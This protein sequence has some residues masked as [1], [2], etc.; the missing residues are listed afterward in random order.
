MFKINLLLENSSGFLMTEALS[1]TRDK[2]IIV[3]ENSYVGF[4]IDSDTK[5]PE[6]SFIWITEFSY[7]LKL[8]SQSSQVFRYAVARWDFPLDFEVGFIKSTIYD[9]LTINIAKVFLNQSPGISTIF[10]ELGEDCNL[11]EVGKIEVKLEKISANEV[12]DLFEY[13]LEKGV[14][15]WEPFSK[16]YS[17]GNSD[18]KHIPIFLLLRRLIDNLQVVE[19]LLPLFAQSPRSKLDKKMLTVPYHSNVNIDEDSIVWLFGNSEALNA[20]IHPGINTVKVRNQFYDIDNIHTGILEESSDVY[21]NRVIYGFFLNLYSYVQE[22]LTRI[23]IQIERLS[24]Y[25]SPSESLIIIQKTKFLE[26]QKKDCGL[27]LSKIKVFKSFWEK[28]L[29][30][31]SALQEAPRHWEKFSSTSH[32]LKIGK[33]INEWYQ[34][35]NTG[36]FGIEHLYFGTRTVDKLFELTCLFKLVDSIKMLGYKSPEFTPVLG[37]RFIE[38]ETVHQGYYDFKSTLGLARTLRLWYEMLPPGYTTIKKSKSGLRPDFIL[39]FYLN[40]VQEPQ[41]LIFD[42]KYKAINNLRKFQYNEIIPKYLHGIGKLDGTSN[43]TRGLYILFPED[44]SADY[45]KYEF[46]QKPEFNLFS[47]KPSMPSIGMI[48]VPI[49]KLKETEIKKILTRH[50]SISS[51]N[52]H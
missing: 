28:Y 9:G 17:L 45:V 11:A 51:Y 4:L 13:L 6:N 41:L 10:V 39:E 16:T 48:Q 27:L 20:T 15:Y 30:T 50:L 18:A 42:A 43:Q 1:P 5:L 29:P 32:Y 25:S 37:D 31:K 23:E 8:V 34:T 44:K 47:K 2:D 22:L 52:F 35:K 19:S 21:E 7:P 14:S 40:D 49:G 3:S 33:I 26:H 38:D 36:V 12:G 46:Y 24:L